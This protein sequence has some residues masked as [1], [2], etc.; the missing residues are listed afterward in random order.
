MGAAAGGPAGSG[1][2]CGVPSPSRGVGQRAESSCRLLLWHSPPQ[3]AAPLSG[4]SQ[5]TQT[6]HLQMH[7]ADNAGLLNDKSRQ[8]KEKS[9]SELVS[10]KEQLS[11]NCLMR[12]RGWESHIRGPELQAKEEL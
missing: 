2:V 11:E 1:A 9:L 8:Q 10:R 6:F 3:P 4:L 7:S 5:V 12:N